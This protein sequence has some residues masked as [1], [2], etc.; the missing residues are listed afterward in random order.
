MPQIFEAERE[1]DLLHALSRESE[2]VEISGS[3]RYP[4]K[5]LGS[6]ELQALR[7]FFELLLTWDETEHGIES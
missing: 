1:T 7:E 2:P 4:E 6:E 3:Q 5:Y